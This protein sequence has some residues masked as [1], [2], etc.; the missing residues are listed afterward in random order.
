MLMRAGG[1]VVGVGAVIGV[2]VAT[3]VAIAPW[4]R[5]NVPEAAEVTPQV[6]SPVAKRAETRPAPV[7]QRA[8]QAA[9]A[10][11]PVVA[12]GRTDLGD[13]VYADRAGS[14]VTVNFDNSMLR[15]RFEE[16]FE[17]TVRATLPRVFGAD[18]KAAL[19]SVAEGRLVR[20]DLLNTLPTSGIR[21]AVAD[22]RALTLFPMTRPGEDG[23]LVIGYRAV[24]AR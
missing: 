13:S 21:L 1:L 2:L 14:E 4:S 11:T 22:G 10:L 15:T 23:P 16:K 24:V 8:P 12:E 20:G 3:L 19:D 17:R 6:A 18:A 9:A 5:S 7:T